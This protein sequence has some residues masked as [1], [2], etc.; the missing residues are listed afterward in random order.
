MPKGEVPAVVD[1]LGRAVPL[2]GP[3]KGRRIVSLVPSLTELLFAL[4]AGARVAGVSDYCLFPEAEL[5][6]LPRVGG[7][8]DPDL[9]RLLSLSPDLVLCAK[10][11][12]LRRDVEALGRAGVPVYVTD[13]RTVEDALLLPRQLG[14]LCGAEE[15]AVE[16][17]AAAM[18]AGIAKARAEGRRRGGAGPRRR[19]LV[20][21]WREP[22]IVAGSDTYIN[23][24]LSLCGAANAAADLAG[25][26]GEPGRR[27]PKAEAAALRALGADLVLLPS[28]PY[29]FAEAHVEEAAA[30]LGARAVLCDG[31]VLFWYGPRMA[32]L[33]EVARLLWA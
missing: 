1:A 24:V 8:K 26:P 7:Q 21:V 2:G 10:E 32:R 22:W 11:E 30:E 16:A 5:A 25:L 20:P 27:Y 15:G 17:V 12:N 23:E 31:T 13:V 14:P 29:P 28:E 6:A 18:A 4:G 3:A 19:V 9:G 33:G